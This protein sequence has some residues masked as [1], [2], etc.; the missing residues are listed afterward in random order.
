LAILDCFQEGPALKLGTLAKQLVDILL[1]VDVEGSRALLSRQ[2]GQSSVE[3][4]I[5]PA[6]EHIGQAWEEGE[7][8]LSQVYMAGRICEE[9]MGEV[10][11]PDRSRLS[12]RPR[13]AIG[14]IEDYHALGKRMVIAALRSSGYDPLDYGQGLKAAELV[15]RALSDQVDILLISCLM[16]SSAVRVKDVVAG[17]LAAGS[18]TMVVVGGAPFRLD[19][20]LWQE[21]G[22]HARGCN[23]ADAVRIVQAA[24][25]GRVWK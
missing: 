10:L 13:L 18:E 23:S 17:L 6:L 16:L 11:P 4:I 21:V 22:A 1:R 14:V 20:L 25:E 19:P 2:D 24:R 3:N 12:E 9:V 8:S 15:E 7:V 5:V